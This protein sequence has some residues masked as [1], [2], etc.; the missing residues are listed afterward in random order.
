[1]FIQK[2]GIIAGQRIAGIGEYR[3]RN[4]RAN[5]VVAQAQLQSLAYYASTDNPEYKS[6]QAQIDS[7]K[8]Q[9][10]QLNRS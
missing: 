4:S 8:Q 5:L 9:L 10:N 6:L 3:K 7:Y 2:N 1:M